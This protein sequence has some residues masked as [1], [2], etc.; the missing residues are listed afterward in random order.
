MSEANLSNRGRPRTPIVNRLRVSLW[1]QL[2]FLASGF[3]EV[4]ELEA[5]FDKTPRLKL[6]SGLWSRYMRGEVLPQGASDFLEKRNLIHR[7]AKLF[8]EPFEV[9]YAPF[10]NFLVWDP[11]VDLDLMKACYL[12]L[13][14]GINVWFVARDEIDGERK[15]TR[16]GQ[17]WY[18][19][20]AID[21]RRKIVANVNAWDGLLICL[22]EAK[23]S[24]G[25]QDVEAFADS[26]M[27]ACKTIEKLREVPEYQTKRLQGVFLTMEA[28]CL[29]TLVRNLAA[30]TPLSKNQAQIRER[31]REMKKLWNTKCYEHAECLSKSS[32]Q[33]FVQTLEKSTLVGRRTR[34]N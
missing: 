4:Q 7:V 18:H 32:R 33:A 25:A 15:A 20:R 14:D 19:K 22:L 2:V 6:A 11:F 12:T 16:Y 9:F 26:Q 28:L 3:D 31:V 24:F 34:N 17:F 29:D 21:A 5:L 8:P 10:W 13:D 27:L 23:M 30:H 1:S